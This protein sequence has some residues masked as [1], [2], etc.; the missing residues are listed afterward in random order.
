MIVS[1]RFLRGKE[2]FALQNT[3]FCGK[4]AGSGKI[5]E[6]IFRFLLTGDSFWCKFESMKGGDKPER[7]IFA[8]N[9]G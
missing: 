7:T 6:K 9:A 8:V 1:I 4:K 2:E 5:F 3:I